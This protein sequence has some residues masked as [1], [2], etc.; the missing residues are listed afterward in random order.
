MK[1]ISYLVLIYLIFISCEDTKKSVSK[2]SSPITKKQNVTKMNTNTKKDTVVKKITYPEI[3]QDNVVPFLTEYGKNNLETKV[4]INTIYGDIFIELFKD[5]PLHRANFI[6]LIKQN[7]F[8]DSFFHRVVP[9][10]I[11]QGGDSD[12]AITPKKRSKIGAHYRIPA[13]IKHK[14]IQYGHICG[15]KEYRENPDKLSA[16]FEF[17]I[18]LGPPSSTRHLNGNYT[19]FGKVTKGMKVVEKI[20]NLPADK[21]EWPLENVYINVEIIE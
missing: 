3:T 12:N 7:Y 18:F 2:H 6:Y 10:F 17:F 16:P 11:I 4:K 21:G 19:V 5:T 9:N 8:E 1:T 14:Q 13:E 15:A 20:A